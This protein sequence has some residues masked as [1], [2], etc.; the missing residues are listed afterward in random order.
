MAFKITDSC[1]KCGTCADNCP[2]G[3]ITEGETQYEINED[4]CLSCGLCAS[5]C[6]V[7]AIEE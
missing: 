6:P 7:D 5:N 1:I 3:A 2:V 4:E